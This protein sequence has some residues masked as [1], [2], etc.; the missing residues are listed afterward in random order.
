VRPRLPGRGGERK[1]S[2]EEEEEEEE[3]E[4]AARAQILGPPAPPGSAEV[5]RS[6]PTDSRGAGRF[7]PSANWEFHLARSFSPHML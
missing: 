1:G 7:Q 4:E 2:N 5:G 3:E 6:A